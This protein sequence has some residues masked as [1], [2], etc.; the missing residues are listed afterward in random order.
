MAGRRNKH[1]AKANWQFKTADGPNQAEETVPSVR[2]AKPTVGAK[3][4]PTPR[5]TVPERELLTAMCRAERIIDVEDLV[6]AWVC[7][8]LIDESRG[9]PRRLRPARRSFLRRTAGKSGK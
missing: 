5:E 6:F 2:P 9:E 7:A 1:H 3:V 8:G 4:C